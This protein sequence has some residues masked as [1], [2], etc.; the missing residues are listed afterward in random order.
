MWA[1][2]LTQIQKDEIEIRKIYSLFS[3][4]STYANSKR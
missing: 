1:K 2:S 3:A 4:K